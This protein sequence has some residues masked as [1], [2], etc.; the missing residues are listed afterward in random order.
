MKLTDLNVGVMVTV[1]DGVATVHIACDTDNGT[2]IW[3]PHLTLSYD[4]LA[5]G[6]IIAA[7][8]LGDEPFY[9]TITRAVSLAASQRE[10]DRMQALI[11]DAY[12]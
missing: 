11:K 3:M 1:V 4:N 5:D 10:R 6:K 12:L 8:V 7:V 9:K 2:K